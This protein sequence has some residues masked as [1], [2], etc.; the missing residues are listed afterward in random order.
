[1]I[2]FTDA[3]IVH[4][5]LKTTPSIGWN[6]LHGKG[7]DFHRPD[8]VHNIYIGMCDHLLTWIRSILQHCRISKVIDVIWAHNCP[9]PNF[10][11]RSIAYQWISQ[12]ND[13]EMWNFGQNIFLA[14]AA[15]LNDTPSLQPAI[16]LRALTYSQLPVYM[17]LVENH[18]THTTKTPN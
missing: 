17:I 15:S 16:L 13:T 1:V 9:Y 10:S 12:C 18:Q 6:I 7:Y 3:W 14:L 4:V 5:S 11:Y 2:K 8:I